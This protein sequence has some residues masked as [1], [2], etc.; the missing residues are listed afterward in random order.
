MRHA[1]KPRQSLTFWMVL[2]AAL[3]A[4][5]AP[6][7]AQTSII[8]QGDAKPAVQPLRS[9]VS[10]A[11]VGQNFV[12]GLASTHVQGQSRMRM[13]LGDAPLSELHVC[14]G[15]WGGPHE[16]VGSGDITVEAAIES[17]NPL[18]V[19]RFTWS[20]VNTITL[21][22]GQTACS[23]ALYPTA[24]GLAVFPANAAEWFRTGVVAASSTGFPFSYLLSGP[25]EGMYA[26]PLFASQ[27][28]A[29]GPMTTPS[30]GTPAS[31]ML[32]PFAVLGRYTVA[33]PTLCD[34]G[35]SISAGIE[36]SSIAEQQSQLA[37]HGY[38][39]RAAYE[40]DGARIYPTF[41]LAISGD[42]ADDG[43][44]VR[45]AGFFRYCTHGVAAWGVNDIQIEGPST[46]FS[47]L[48]TAWAL[49]HADGIQYIYQTTLTPRTTSTDGWATAARQKAYDFNFVPG[50]P[51]DQL[52]FLIRAG[53]GTNFLTGIVDVAA[54]VQAKDN[55]DIWLTNGSS[56]YCTGD[57][58]HPL[59]PCHALM[60]PALITALQSAGPQ[61]PTPNDQAAGS[62]D[63]PMDAVANNPVAQK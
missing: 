56:G 63:H 22:P 18:G 55:I 36:D 6:T 15:N 40:S 57:G 44:Y 5:G 49:M 35:D 45:R 19:A 50:G 14:Y 16:A 59:G 34:I 21:T 29:T 11:M 30:G 25:G 4:A 42:T 26:G 54:R 47:N 3:V 38:V 37:G 58:L 43:G 28:N 7:G 60:A 17:D 2:G 41:R 33:M 62:R 20:G 46:V 24:F 23:D 48:K 1:R 31:G 9:A 39:G 61:L 12:A 52:N 8:K 53:V 10:R 51:R 27:V 13:A 32:T